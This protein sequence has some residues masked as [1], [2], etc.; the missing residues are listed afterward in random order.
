MKR[1]ISIISKERLD[2]VAQLGKLNSDKVAVVGRAVARWIRKNIT[3]GSAVSE[4]DA[5]RFVLDGDLINDV[6]KELEASK[7]G[8]MYN[9]L[10]A[11]AAE[12][13]NAVEAERL[14]KEYADF[15]S[16]YIGR[17]TN[18]ASYVLAHLQDQI[19]ES[20]KS[21]CHTATTIEVVSAEL[22]TRP[23]IISVEILVEVPDE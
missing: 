4:I 13:G 6:E 11:Q 18:S 1:K 2:L 12:D 3:D 21:C 16:K 20:I 8:E 7:R 23:T 22:L 19:L 10:I 9:T 17:L 14:I 5:F 15:K